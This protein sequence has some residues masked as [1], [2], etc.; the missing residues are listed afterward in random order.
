MKKIRYRLL[1]VTAGLWMALSAYA[2]EGMFLPSE[3]AKYIG[4]MQSAGFKLSADDIYNINNA[5]LKDAIVQFA[6]YCTGEIVSSQGLLFTNHHCGY[7]SIAE[8]STTGSNLL[9]KGFWA[10]TFEQEIPVP[11]LTVSILISVTDV[12]DRVNKAADKKSEMK[13]ITDEAQKASGYRA[14]VKSMFQGNEYYLMVYRV[15]RDIR[16]VGAPPSSIGNYGGDTDNWFWPR[17]TGDFSVF[18][19][20]AGADNNP[21]DYSPANKPYKPARHLKINARGIKQGDFAMIMGFPGSTDRYLTAADVNKTVQDDYP[22]KVKILDNI[23][24]I[25][26]KAMDKN[27]QVRINLAASFAQQANG[28][29]YFKG[30][31]NAMRTSAV[32]TE[33]HKLQ[34]EF[35]KWADS[36]ASKRSRYGTVVSDI[37]AI[38]KASVPVQKLENYLFYGYYASQIPRIGFDLYGLYQE[39]STSKVPSPE[40]LMALRG[41]VEDYFEKRDLASEKQIFAAALRL[42]FENLPQQ[43]QIA[44]YQRKEF[45]KMKDAAGKDRFDAYADYVYS[46]SFMADR[47]KLEAFLSKPSKKAMDADPGFQYTQDFAALYGTYQVEAGANSQKLS[48]LYKTYIAGLREFQKDKYFY[49]DANFTLR[50]TYG[51]VKPYDPR[52]GMSYNWYTTSTGILEKYKPGD[53]EFNIDDKLKDLLE[54]KDFGRYGTNGQLNICFLADLDITGGNS[55]S[56]VLDAE[57]ALIG[58][59]FDGVWEG[60]VGDIYFDES[61]NRTI[62]V[63]VRYV[64]FVIEK[65]G[66]CKRLIDEM[67]ILI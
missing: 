14:E 13:A 48:D 20:Y 26:E 51:H 62:S 59:A 55:G 56:P 12:T 21:A 11:G 31:I 57:G 45:L 49:P 66:N 64:L 34:Q 24:D 43:H 19:I 40:T 53:K 9:D 44:T 28:A 52:D 16:L 2:G 30:V 67:D 47:A 37:D 46:K 41:E 6:N 60:L 36:D 22:D 7:E 8:L 18:R 39:L 25:M 23:L 1:G 4:G 61:K 27:E 42:G 10:Q 5:S 17:H 3:V 32:M 58:I 63:D 29:K 15:Y 35:I 38:V 33:K 54:K 65:Y 50:L